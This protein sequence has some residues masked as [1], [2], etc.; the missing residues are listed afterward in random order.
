VNVSSVL[1]ATG[2]PNNYSVAVLVQTSSA[3]PEP[4][5][6]LLVASGLGAVGAAVR[7]RRKA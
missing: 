5:T 6:L 4:A 3:T 2:T 7:R 1:G